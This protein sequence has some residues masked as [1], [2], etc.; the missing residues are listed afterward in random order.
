MDRQ[1]TVGSNGADV[2][3]LQTLL[4]RSPPSQLPPLAVDKIF[5]PKTSARVKEFQR[6]SGLQVD[7]IVGPRTWAK[8]RGT[9][10]RIVPRTGVCCGNV[11]SAN[12]GRA[13][14]IRQSLASKFDIRGGLPAM[15]SIPGIS[16]LRPLTSAQIATAR[17]VFGSSLD[18]SRIYISDQAGLGGR[19]FT[20]AIPVL[21]S[22]SVQVINC[23]TFS[24]N[25]A[26][27]IHELAHVWQS[28][29][30]SNPYEF[31]SN[32][33]ASQAAAVA[34]NGTMAVT[35]RS[36]T[37]DPDFPVHYPCS[38]YA[39]VAGKPFGEYAAEQ[40]ANAVEHGVSAI[41]AHVR[42]VA[43]GVV[44]GDNV[45]SLKKT[46]VDDRRAPGIIF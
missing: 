27:L 26:T 29:H 4:N 40:I 14:S 43:A 19:P 36:I 28:Q 30:H 41:V 9:Q 32:A 22:Q 17:G 13:L 1:L 46:Q 7:G 44:D 15:V 11:D 38:A 2:S 23:G 33:V 18:F 12:Q 35:D 45:K 6:N 21:L 34:L 5:G 31:M 37:S 24:P 16:S 39:F 25:T 8:L 10:P 20:V 3:E 42:S